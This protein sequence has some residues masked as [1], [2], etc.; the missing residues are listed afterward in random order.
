MSTTEL[1]E[2][3]IETHKAIKDRLKSGLIN[4]SSLARKIAKELDIEKKTTKDAILITARRYKEKI[5]KEK[6]KEDEIKLLLKQSEIE[7]KNKVSVF[8]LEKGIY[9][10]NF[11]ELEKKVRENED[12]FFSVEGT[13]SITLIISEKYS[14]LVNKY[15]KNRVVNHRGKNAVVI[16]KSSKDIENVSG[17]LG[18]VANLFSDNNVNIVESMSCW[19]DTIFIV[20]E[21]D[22]TK[23]M[24]FM[25]F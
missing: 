8:I 10:D 24:E 4:Y 2:K 25:R 21:D 13:K 7:I 23:I 3:Y 11:I 14:D 22:A 20:K 12:I 6:L 16:I 5:R 9:L 1:T 18:Y 15:F 19:T 17:V